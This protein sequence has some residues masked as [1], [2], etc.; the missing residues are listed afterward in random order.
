MATF[1]ERCMG[2]PY[3]EYVGEDQLSCDQVARA[4]LLY[5]RGDRDASWLKSSMSLT[6]EQGNE[7]DEILATMPTSLLTVVN[8]VNRSQWP[9]KV[10]V[11]LNY[12]AQ[13]HADYDTP[14]KV[15]TALGL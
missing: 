1:I 11:L 7:L 2:Y 12:G 3:G 15:R 5:S 13:A 14:A 4:L 6:T 8:A 10:G 9:D